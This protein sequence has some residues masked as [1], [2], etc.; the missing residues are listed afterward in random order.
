MGAR[1]KEH[2]ETVKHSNLVQS[3]GFEPESND[4]VIPFRKTSH[5][6]DATEGEYQEYQKLSYQPKTT[7]EIASALASIK[8]AHGTGGATGGDNNNLGTDNSDANGDANQDSNSN[9]A[10]N[11]SGANNSNGA[12][13]TKFNTSD[14]AYQYFKCAG[15][16][17]SG[18]DLYS[19]IFCS[20]VGIRNI[21]SFKRHL[22]SRCPGILASI[23][24]EVRASSL[25]LL[26][27]DAKVRK[28]RVGRPKKK[29]KTIYGS[30]DD[31]ATFSDANFYPTLTDA[32]HDDDAGKA[33]QILTKLFSEV[34]A[35][36]AAGKK[37]EEKNRRQS[38]KAPKRIE[39][40]TEEEFDQ[41]I[42][43]L[44]VKKMRAE[45]LELEERIENQALMRK[46]LAGKIRE[47]EERIKLLKNLNREFPNLL[48]VVNLLI[49]P[50]AKNE[51]DNS[52]GGGSVINSGSNS[53]LEEA[54]AETI[55]GSN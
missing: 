16:N 7:Q 18:N 36:G 21:R 23:R 13:N 15:V 34:S 29:R 24:E 43:M 50:E 44:T 38:K 12:K 49:T 11:S 39:E 53:L 32:E 51:L 37:Q 41:E 45:L 27:K 30:D 14:Q 55:S 52:L 42:K 33:V 31:G 40:F 3:A 8:E 22:V 6:D 25:D 2:V 9:G 19:C 35:G 1:I 17:E 10:N 26:E 46:E 48:R 5:P 54:F 28:E 4:H 47:R 20:Y